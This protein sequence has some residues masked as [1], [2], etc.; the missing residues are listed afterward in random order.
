MPELRDLID[1][2]GKLAKNDPGLFELLMRIIIKDM[3][4]S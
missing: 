1:Q 4:K 2:P 3:E